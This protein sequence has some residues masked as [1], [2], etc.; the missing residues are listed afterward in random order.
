MFSA[1][2]LFLNLDRHRHNE[3][4]DHDH[5][6]HNSSRIG[7]PS[8][9]EESARKRRERDW[10]AE[11]PLTTSGYHGSSTYRTSSS[12]YIET[13]R[14]LRPDSTPSTS[15]SSR[16]KTPWEREYIK[17]VRY[18]YTPLATPSYMQN[19]WMKGGDRR[20]RRITAPTPASDEPQTPFVPVDERELAAEAEKLDRN[21]YLMDD[22]YDLDNNPFIGRSILLF[23]PTDCI[24]NVDNFSYYPFNFSPRCP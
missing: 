23:L 2:S 5:S 12:R 4:D 17:R 22:G 10:E 20:D 13:P 16:P 3:H 24:H 7:R 19:S 21:W 1:D 15:R 11:T 6:R 18:D 9:A 14:H 8:E